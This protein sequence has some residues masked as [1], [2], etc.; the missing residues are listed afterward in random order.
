MLLVD[1][2][3]GVGDERGDALGVLLVRLDLRVD[4]V[5]EIVK[6]RG[7]VGGK[8]PE[9][10]RERL[11]VPD[12]PDA[13][14]VAGRLGRVGGADAALGGANLVS[15]ELRLAQ[16]VNLLVEVEEHV[17]AV[18][19]D[20]ARC[21]DLHPR[22]LEGID[23]VEHTGEV[24]HHAVAHDALG[25]LVEDAGGHE[26]EGV[27][28][29]LIVVDGVARVGAALA[30]RDDVVLLFGSD[31]TEDGESRNG[32]RSRIGNGIERAASSGPEA[33]GAASHRSGAGV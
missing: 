12:V 2:V 13:D 22:L 3:H 19:D 7:G 8:G 29:A 5:L 14:A 27:L 18:G 16:A 4:V 1:H 25:L 26:M 31:G 9:L 32:L 11:G 28:F 23:L 10:L 21:V 33:R 30:P 15:G 6:P 20:Q 24:D 17:R